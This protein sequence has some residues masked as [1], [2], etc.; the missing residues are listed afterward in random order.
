[1]KKV[2][3]LTGFLATLDALAAS[4]QGVAPHRENV[5]RTEWGGIIVDTCVGFD[6]GEWETGIMRD[7]HRDGAC[8]IAEQ[9]ENEEQAKAGHAKWVAL[10]QADPNATCPAL[11]LWE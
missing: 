5:L 4:E 10:L 2:D 11:M 1:M 6:T 9:Y 7:S 3:A 8:E